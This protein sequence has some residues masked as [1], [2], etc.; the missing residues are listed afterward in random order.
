M[1]RQAGAIFVKDGPATCGP[2][3]ILHRERYVIWSCNWRSLESGQIAGLMD[4]PPL[5]SR[6]PL[7]NAQTSTHSI[8]V[9]SCAR[10]T[11]KGYLVAALLCSVGLPKY[12]SDRRFFLVNPIWDL[13]KISSG[14]QQQMNRKASHPYCP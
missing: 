14:I 11:I 1:K 3:E 6:G 13:V 10:G 7:Y 5:G 12:R 8:V 2:V 4:P 9:C